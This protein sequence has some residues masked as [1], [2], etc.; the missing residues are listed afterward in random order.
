M[1]AGVVVGVATVA[2]T[3]FAVTTDAEVTVPEPPDVE[4]EYLFP[5]ESS[6]SF[7]VIVTLPE[8]EDVACVEVPCTT[9]LPEIVPPVSGRNETEE[10]A[11]E[12]R[13][14]VVAVPP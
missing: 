14:V 7:E 8:K 12:P 11:F 3:P 2:D 1:N 9:R 13:A 4:V 10:K 6:R 5:P